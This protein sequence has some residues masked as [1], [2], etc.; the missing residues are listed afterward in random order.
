[1]LSSLQSVAPSRKVYVSLID[2]QPI[3]FNLL[4][5]FLATSQVNSF[6]QSIKPNEKL[7]G[8]MTNVQM[9]FANAEL[10]P[11][12]ILVFGSNFYVAIQPDGRILTGDAHNMKLASLGLQEK[13]HGP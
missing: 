10:E 9:G 3:N 6:V 1:M 5:A 8:I 12:G 4:T 13:L 7:Y 2:Q 11:G